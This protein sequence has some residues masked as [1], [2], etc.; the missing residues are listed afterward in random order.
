[1]HLSLI[2]LASLSAACVSMLAAWID[3]RT[4]RIPN[5][6]TL[7]TT[8]VGLVMHGAVGGVNAGMTSALG[9]IA[10]LVVPAVLYKV[11]SGKAI[12]GGDVK[13]FAALGA[14]MGPMLVIETQFGS[15]VLLAVFAIIRLAFRGALLRVLGNS[16]MLLFNPF[17]PKKWRREI[18][19][20]AMTEMRLGPA[21]A[22]AVLSTLTVE[23]YGRMLPWL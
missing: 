14:L 23:R 17:L 5:A 7:P 8:A 10:G 13:L 18:Q 11:S 6:L 9:V 3:H 2:A 21:I 1:M 12:G 22:V 19:P 15:F 16:M 4:G 20:E